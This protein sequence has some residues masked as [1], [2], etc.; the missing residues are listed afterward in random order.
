MNKHRMT[1]DD[2]RTLGRRVGPTQAAD[3]EYF[4]R[5]CKG[6]YSR[7]VPVESFWQTTCRCGSRNLLI[8]SVSSEGAAPLRN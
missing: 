4:C 5:T 1:A 8:Y 7:I 3:V 6:H 2:R